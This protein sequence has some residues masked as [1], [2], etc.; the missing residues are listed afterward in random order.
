M[1][2]VCKRI[3]NGRT[4]NGGSAWMTANTNLQV[5]PRLRILTHAHDRPKSDS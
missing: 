3:A 5:S 2:Q 4:S 1:Q